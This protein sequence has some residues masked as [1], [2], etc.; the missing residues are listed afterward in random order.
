MKRRRFTLIE[1]LIVIAI[2]AILASMLLPA[3][4]RAKQRGKFARWLAYSNN[5]RTD[6]ELILYYNFQYDDE[7][8]DKVT[9]KAYGLNIDRYDPEQLDGEYG[10]QGWWADGRFGAGKRGMFNPDLG[11]IRTAEPSS[12]GQAYMDVE[13]EITVF[14]WFRVLEFKRNWQ[15]IFAKGDSAW[16]ISRM[17]TSDR[18]HF[19]CSGLS[20]T[21]NLNSVNGVNDDKWHLAVGTYDGATLSLYLDGELEASGPATG[22]INTNNYRVEVGANQQQPMRDHVGWIDEVGVFTRALSAAEVR[23]MYGMGAP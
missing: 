10:N 20:G 21:W 17:G 1:L 3:L 14:T 2:I 19:A 7:G 16:R 18:I 12:A 11:W 23:D 5:L 15:A 4:G 22:K 8:H 6:D 9:N 13:D